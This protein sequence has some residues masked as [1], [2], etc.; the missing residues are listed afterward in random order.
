MNRMEEYH[1]LIQKLEQPVPALEHSFDR[2]RRKQIRRRRV[3]RPLVATAAS[4]LLFVGLVNLSSS[5]ATVCSKIPFLAE[6]AE[7]VTFSDSLTDAVAN[8]YVQ[9]LALSRT[10]G[11]V[12]VTLEH[13]IADEKRVTVF[14]RL[15][16]DIYPEL[17]ALVQE[18]TAD[19]EPV[20]ASHCT[21]NDWTVPNGELQSITLD[22]STDQVP[23]KLYLHLNI[24]DMERTTDEAV[25][26]L[27]P[28][29]QHPSQYPL[30]DVPK[31]DYEYVAHFDFTLELDPAYINTGAKKYSINK[32]F[33]I[34]HQTITVTDMEV[35]PTH[36][37]LNVSEDPDNTAWLNGLDF[38]IITDN[39]IKQLPSFAGVRA[40]MER[41]TET[42]SYT[43]SYY[44]ES[45]YF[46]ASAHYE[47]VIKSAFWETKEPEELIVNLQTGEGEQLAEEITVFHFA[48]E[49]D[50]W[51]IEFL[52][53]SRHS[54]YSTAATFYDEEGT[55]YPLTTWDSKN[56][57]YKTSHF[58]QTAPPEG[59]TFE[60]MSLEIIHSYEKDIEEP[61]T[62]RVK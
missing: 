31:E 55:P 18:V 29:M 25:L 15:D 56:I 43:G 59:H 53:N 36:L 10:D 22:Y 50:G 9:P 3:I 42:Q 24:L 41:D 47:I 61:I 6:L 52:R 11:D 17:K 16:S 21:L 57:G 32:T 34:N 51:L 20:I 35:Y 14:F 5:V 8:Q 60:R 38:Q 13:A 45:P 27:V 62:I 23:D 2:A 40:T 7:A 19:G 33:T 37:R 26:Q 4:F 49:T 58:F 44:A 46:D 28:T 48:K 1:N 39:S 30:E 54:Y 12:T